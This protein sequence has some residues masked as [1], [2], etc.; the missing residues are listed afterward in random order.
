MIYICEYDNSV[1]FEI[2]NQYAEQLP[3]PSYNGPAD[4]VKWQKYRERILAWMLL[5]HV[6]GREKMN[7]LDIQRT[8]YGK[9]YSAAEPEFHFNISHCEHA[10]ACIFS[11]AACGVDVE[12]KF[13][14][15]E[16]LIRKVCHPEEYE[17]LSRLLPEEREQQ[18]RFLWSLKESYVKMDGRGLGYGL[19]S[20]N[21]ASMLPI[22]AD[23]V[24]VQDTASCIA[25]E[26]DKY[27]LAGYVC[28]Q[29]EIP[30]H[31]LSETEL[32]GIIRRK[33]TL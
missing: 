17:M 3:I 25:R 33:D 29:T 5:Q 2:L 23:S 26:Y 21:L 19:N 1:S 13:E 32:F 15:K 10:C 24:E 4:G 8:K 27:T 31:V 20:V 16:N 30:V 9:P 12:K 7:G 28:K 14:M 22:Q 6:I 18:M 11:D